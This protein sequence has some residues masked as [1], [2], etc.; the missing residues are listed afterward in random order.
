MPV[1]LPENQEFKKLMELAGWNQ[2]E[3]AQRLGL[4][5]ASV[6]DYINGKT[7]PKHPTL[8]FFRRLV[9]ERAD[10]L[11]G[12]TGSKSIIQNT[13]GF[14]DLSPEV[15]ESV[16]K[17]FAEH[18]VIAAPKERLPLLEKLSAIAAALARAGEKKP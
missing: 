15:L 14:E 3:T 7:P 10:D 17:T 16:F 12:N 4:S 2:S 1:L 8:E 5:P 18:L 11:R 13:T 9:Q 6:S